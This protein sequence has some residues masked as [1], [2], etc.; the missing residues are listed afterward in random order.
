MQSWLDHEN[1][2]ALW[3]QSSLMEGILTI[4][5]PGLNP[6]PRFPA[7][8]HKTPGKHSWQPCQTSLR[9]HPKKMSVDTPDFP[10]VKLARNTSKSSEL[11]S[12]TPHQSILIRD[13]EW[14]DP[15]KTKSEYSYSGSWTIE[16]SARL[17]SKH[18]GMSTNF[19]PLVPYVYCFHCFGWISFPACSHSMHMHPHKIH[20]H[21]AAG[22]GN[23]DLVRNTKFRHFFPK[24]PSHGGVSTS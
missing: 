2:R 16:P 7:G 18:S 9:R 22:L 6:A 14:F 24:K 12:H 21:P 23:D 20:H 5:F 15:S 4:F 10:I 19:D 17:G 1:Y 13:K 3:H 8:Q 11:R